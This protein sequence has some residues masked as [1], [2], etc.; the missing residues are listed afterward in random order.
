MDIIEKRVNAA[1][2]SVRAVSK[3]K[4]DGLT[5]AHVDHICDSLTKEVGALRNR[6]EHSLRPDFRIGSAETQGTD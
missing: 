3:T 4:L 5:K 2:K 1:M 6:L